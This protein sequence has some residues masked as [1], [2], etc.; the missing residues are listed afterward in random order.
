ME[1][2]PVQ[3]A[4]KGKTPI[5]GGKAVEI[6]DFL[7]MWLEKGGYFCIGTEWTENF[8]SRKVQNRRDSPRR[9]RDTEKIERKPET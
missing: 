1:S 5:F 9:H 3:K 6:R 7:W 4:F 8:A 2:T